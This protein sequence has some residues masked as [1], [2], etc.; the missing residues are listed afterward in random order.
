[1]RP[2]EARVPSWRAGF[3]HNGAHADNLIKSSYAARPAH[4]GRDARATIA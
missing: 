4:F 1:M 3:V 2:S